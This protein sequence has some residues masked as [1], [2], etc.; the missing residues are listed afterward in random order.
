MMPSKREITRPTAAAVPHFIEELRAFRLDDR[1]NAAHALG[2]IG[3]AAAAAVPHLIK[4]IRG[5]D[6]MVRRAAIWALR[7]IGERIPAAVISLIEVLYGGD[8]MLATMAESALMVIGGWPANSVERLRTYALDIAESS[9]VRFKALDV[10]RQIA[11]A[12]AEATF[13]A[14]QRAEAAE[15]EEAKDKIPQIKLFY[16]VWR[17]YMEGKNSLRGASDALHTHR[18]KELAQDDLPGFSNVSLSKHIR[19]L[20]PLFKGKLNKDLSTCSIGRKQGEGC[21]SPTTPRRR[22]N[23]RTNSCGNTWQRTGSASSGLCR[24]MRDTGIPEV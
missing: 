9:E 22:G 11:P 3:P 14:W 12:E 1:I 23:G 16:L 21:S 6:F 15:Q 10:L 24:R 2:A 20:E 18:L 7:R 13:I 4:A 19:S 8:P 5:P 17:T